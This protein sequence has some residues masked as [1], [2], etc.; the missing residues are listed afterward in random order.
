VDLVRRRAGPVGDHL[1]KAQVPRASYRPP[2]AVAMPVPN[3]DGCQ[4]SALPP[5]DLRD[6]RSLVSSRWMNAS[7]SSTVSKC[8]ARPLT[9]CSARPRKE[10]C[11]PSASQESCTTKAWFAGSRRSLGLSISTNAK[12]QYRRLIFLPAWGQSGIGV[13]RVFEHSSKISLSE[14]RDGRDV[15]SIR[16]LPPGHRK[17]LYLAR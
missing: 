3:C 17:R 9:T 4:V 16:S 12:Q 2:G 15:C 13:L 7:S 1:P 5:L 10:S 6:S 8:V 14:D 11:V